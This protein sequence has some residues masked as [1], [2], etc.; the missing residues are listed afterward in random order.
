MAARGGMGVCRAA[1]MP[2]RLIPNIG[3]LVSMGLEWA[4]IV[5]AAVSVSSVRIMRASVAHNSVE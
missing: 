4:C 1:T 2:L 5:P 3:L